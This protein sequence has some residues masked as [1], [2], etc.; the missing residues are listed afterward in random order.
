MRNAKI[1]I[2]LEKSI[3]NDQMKTVLLR[4]VSHELRTPLN[5]I[6]FFTNE[7]AENHN[8]LTQK[9]LEKLKIVSV[10]AKLVLSLIEDLLDYSKMLA[11]VFN[12]QKSYC[13]IEKLIH[14]T[15]DLIRY[16]ANK[17][18]VLLYLRLD[19]SI[20][21]VIYTDS[22][23]VS[24]VL[25]NLLSNSLKFTMKGWIEVCATMSDCNELNIS[26]NDTGIGIP[27]NIRQKLFTEFTTSNINSVNPNG[28]GLGL[29]IS[30]ILAKELGLKP[31]K[32]RSKIGKGSTFSFSI[33]TS[34]EN[35]EH[36]E[37]DIEEKLESE[38][39]LDI[40]LHDP[41]INILDSE[42]LIVDDNEFNRIIVGE[43]LQKFNIKFKEA[44]GGK[45]A[46][47]EIINQDQRG[48]SFKVVIMD[49]NMPEM[50]G[51]ET[52]KNLKKLFSEGKLYFF[53][54]IIGH[55]AFTSEEDKKT[56]ISSGMVE[57]LTKPSSPDKIINTLKKYL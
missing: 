5:A 42:V 43:I 14:D 12:I 2:D 4:S 20:P 44:C 53:P 39:K 7:I 50:D 32:V 52:T 35:V 23:R 11:G 26:V 31:I 29:C 16:Q 33:Q 57:H 28:T 34:D 17:K 10:S 19:P 45:E 37:Y 36:F 51:W 49:C 41:K 25:L 56:C 6:T 13:N 21:S 15:M 30:N 24:Q 54:S 55:S 1:I 9:E 22:L 18:N 47:K 40:N 38:K 48:K 27:E 8:N 46:I 3:A